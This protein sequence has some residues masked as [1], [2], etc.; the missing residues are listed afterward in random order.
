MHVVCGTPIHP[1]EMAVGGGA[2]KMRACLSNIHLVDDRNDAE[3]QTPKAPS[4][5]RMCTARPMQHEI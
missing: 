1:R 4:S 5:P 3:E 2:G